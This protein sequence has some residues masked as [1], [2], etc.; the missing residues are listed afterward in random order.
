MHNAC[1]AAHNAQCT[2]KAFA[3]A[4]QKNVQCT[5]HL[6]GAPTLHAATVLPGRPDLGWG[7]GGG[8]QGAHFTSYL[9]YVHNLNLYLY[10]L[11]NIILYL[12][13]IC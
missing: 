12:T 3:G 1:H 9:Y 5:I 10:Y 8:G 7:L 11:F 13:A 4:K 2:S 6:V